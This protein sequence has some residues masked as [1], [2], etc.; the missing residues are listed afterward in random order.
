VAGN[1]EDPVQLNEL[2]S[3]PGTLGLALLSEVCPYGRSKEVSGFRKSRLSQRPYMG[4][5]PKY[6]DSAIFDAGKPDTP[7]IKRHG[8]ASFPGG[9][10]GGSPMF[11]Y[12]EV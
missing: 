11:C 3:D 2:R 10:A 9:E 8:G 6:P 4:L 7:T 1:L 5:T 12:S